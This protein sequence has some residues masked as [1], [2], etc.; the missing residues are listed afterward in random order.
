MARVF[1]DLDQYL[2]LDASELAG[3]TLQ[4]PICGRAHQVPI[5]K[6]RIGEGLIDELPDIAA[7]ILDGKPHKTALIYDRAIEAI[8]QA[9]VI[10]PL[11]SMNLALVGLGESDTL[12][13]P[14]EE[15][16]DEVAGQID[17][18]IDLIVGA[19]SGV[20][21]DLT[22]WIATKVN[23]PFIL[24]GTAPSMNA[25]TSI[26]ATMTRNGVKTSAWLTPAN[27][28]LFDVP[29][30]AGAPKP[31]LLAGLGDLVARTICNADWLLGNLLR[32]TYFC[33]VPF[34]LTGMGEPLYL[35]S[36]QGIGQGKKQDV[37]H[38]GEAILISG[39]SMTMVEGNTSPSSG[40]EHVFSHFWDLQAEMDD[41]PR[42]L[43]GIQV[44]VG[45]LL[46]H[47][48]WDFMRRLDIDGIDPE[49]LL[50]Q[51]PSLETLRSENQARFGSKAPLFDEAILSK[52]IPDEQFMTYIG[53]VLDNWQAIWE[54]LVPYIGQWKIV[55]GNLE[56]AGF[57]FSLDT[58]R[59]TRQQ[60]LDALIYGS[61]YR[62][63][64]TLLDL[65]WELGI[66]PGAADEILDRSG[67]G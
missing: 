43:H 56:S 42:N 41:A 16:G 49:R 30:L 3:S 66:L 65:A 13:E 46:S 67:L 63:R 1:T 57:V 28:V 36:A 10:D 29:I 53:N 23:K 33:P 6:I 22:K 44:G 9:D 55:Q 19:G 60:A 4:C 17:D 64:Y 47:T 32:Q 27:A 34:Q 51:R 35:Q 11:T 26:T 37:H 54:A 59:R 40:C 62:A 39:I 14:L 2:C 18:D 48:L 61:R 52:W 58:I 15:L 8:I 45:T 50:R 21:A 31:M 12:L 24:Y 5:G 7:A 25:H 38:L 20:I